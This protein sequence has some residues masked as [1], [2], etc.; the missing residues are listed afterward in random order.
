MHA[1]TATICA[2][3]VGSWMLVACSA[4]PPPV[5][6]SGARA[7]EPPAALARRIELTAGGNPRLCTREAPP[8]SRVW[9]RVCRTQDEIDRERL[10]SEGLLQELRRKG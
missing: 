10:R 2:P 1:R 9:R 4:G 3:I 7:E 5:A 8:G 6:S